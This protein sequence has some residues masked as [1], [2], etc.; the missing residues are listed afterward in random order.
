MTLCVQLGWVALFASWIVAMVM[1]RFV[2]EV[3]SDV[4]EDG[5][6][7]RMQEG[8]TGNG[9]LG[10]HFVLQYWFPC[11][12]SDTNVMNLTAKISGWYF[13]EDDYKSSW[14]HA[15][16]WSVSSRSALSLIHI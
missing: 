16:K 1:Q 12:K 10:L 11:F 15:L 8:W 3:R 6:R 2:N 14:T 7:C 13:A 5:E 4:D 9:P